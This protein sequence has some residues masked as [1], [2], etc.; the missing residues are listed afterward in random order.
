MRSDCTPGCRQHRSDQR[1]DDVSK[2]DL[3]Q[4][5]YFPVLDC[6]INVLEIRFS[7]NS[8]SAMVGVQRLNPADSSFLDLDKLSSFAPVYN[9]N[10][11]DIHH[12][13]YSLKDGVK[14]TAMLEPASVLEPC[15][16]VFKEVYR[17]SVIARRA[18]D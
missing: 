11:E 12:E 13:V 1:S 14:I 8:N 10:M 15:K 17:L 9:G 3:R 18:A 4:N 7:S 16:L 2:I 6:V 5:I